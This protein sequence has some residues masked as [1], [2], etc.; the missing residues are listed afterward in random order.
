MSNTSYKP[1]SLLPAVYPVE[2]HALDIANAKRVEQLR[3][4]MQT[5]KTLA[6]PRTCPVKFLPLLAHSFGSDFYWELEDLNEAEQREMIANSL[7]LHRRK[8]T[9]W[10]VEKVLSVLG[11]DTEI[12]EWWE[13]KEDLLGIKPTEPYTFIVVADIA[14]LFNITGKAL[15]EY[16]QKR[17]LKYINVYKNVRSHYKMYL[18][19][20]YGNEVALP[21]SISVAEKNDGRGTSPQYKNSGA[22]K[23]SILPAIE[24]KSVDRADMTS[25]QYRAESDNNKVALVVSMSNSE[26][27]R[28][29]GVSPQG[30]FKFAQVGSVGA[31]VQSKTLQRNNLLFEDYTK[32]SELDLGMHG[33]VNAMQ[34]EQIG[35]EIKRPVVSDSHL[36]PV[37]TLRI[38]EVNRWQNP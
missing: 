34:I 30:D 6:N 13:D 20:T 16:E 7:Q 5:I 37:M 27:N 9:R 32:E 29:S 2:E 23:I 31:M 1:T 15:G 33:V 26:I 24:T 28:S 12:T 21:V 25:P 17:L 8:G 36:S 3:L 14:R 4:E 11:V 38:Q 10:A 18:K 22:D 19:A 35:G